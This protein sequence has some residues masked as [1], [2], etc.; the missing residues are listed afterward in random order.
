MKRILLAAPILITLALVACSSDEDDDPTPTQ[1]PAQATATATRPAGSATPP[2]GTPATTPTT[3]GTSAPPVDGTVAPQNA[4]DTQP[5]TIKSNP[6]P[7]SG[8]ATLTDVRVGAHP[9]N[10]GWDRIVFEFAD[11]RPAGEV[12]YVDSVEQCGSGDDVEL[13]GEASLLVSF[14]AANAHTEAGQPTVDTR[15][16]TGPGNA[17][18]ESRQVCDFEAHVDWAIGVKARQNFKV[19]LLESPTRVVIDVKQ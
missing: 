19:T 11:V 8:A 13:P 17:I 3:I 6:D 18:L 15:Q 4:G 10:G 5:F 12:R 9:E 16:I 14:V 7:V 1:P 2:P